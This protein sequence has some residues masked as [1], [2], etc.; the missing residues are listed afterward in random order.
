MWVGKPL[1][2][3]DDPTLLRGLG[4]FI[5]DVPSGACFARFIRSP[6][7]RGRIMR[8]EAP[9]DVALFGAAQ[10]GT[11][12]PI[13]A[14]LHRESFVPLAQPV[15]ATDEVRYAGEPVAV[16]VAD[17]QYTAEDDAAH[18]LCQIRRHQFRGP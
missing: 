18:V 5:G 6:I 1:K 4:A 9:A 17:S 13:R 7:A 16:V 14:L 11:V 15:L 12:R 2:R 10:L 3:F 8:I